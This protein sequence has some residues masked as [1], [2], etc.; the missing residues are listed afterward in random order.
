M[1]SEDEIEA[2]EPTDEEVII[3]AYNV[4]RDG[5]EHLMSVS[6]GIDVTV[7]QWVVVAVPAVAV[8]GG[9]EGFSVPLPPRILVE[10]FV[11]DWMAKG[12]LI[13]GA[14][15]FRRDDFMGTVVDVL[16]DEDEE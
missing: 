10:R 15:S 11:S 5:I 6:M 3:E 13:D 7:Q 16:G 4:V 9:G 12:L 1:T 2:P 8:E 14:D